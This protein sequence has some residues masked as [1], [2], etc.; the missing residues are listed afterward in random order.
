MPMNIYKTFDAKEIERINRIQRNFFS[1][2]VHVFDPPL[3]EGVPERL[4][5]IVFFAE[6]SKGDT[7]LD[8]GSGTGILLP[9]IKIYNPG[10]IYACDLSEA[11]LDTLKAHYPYAETIVTDVRQLRLQDKSI[12]V[13]FVNAC[14]PNLVDKKGVFTNI[15]RII[16]TGGRL[17]ISHPMG[18][19]F[20]AFLKKKSPFPLDDFPQ[21]SEAKTLLE[22]YGFDIEKFVDKPR[23]YILVAVMRYK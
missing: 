8:V 7:V 16:K 2:L 18:K 15:G 1:K 14:Y 12:N 13:V 20:I 6:I 11:M 5:W 19:E 22:P 9:L 3:P 23:L 17:V 4:K 21:Y 10:K